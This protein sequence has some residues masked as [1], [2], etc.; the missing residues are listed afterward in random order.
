MDKN[1][2]NGIL[3]ESNIPEDCKKIISKIPQDSFYNLYSGV[4]NYENINYIELFDILTNIMIFVENIKLN[5]I[6][7]DGETKKNTPP[8]CSPLRGDPPPKKHRKK[9]NNQCFYTVLW[10]R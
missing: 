9:T 5:G 3:Q 8:K 6:K 4:Y 10:R 7:I 1:I 2:K